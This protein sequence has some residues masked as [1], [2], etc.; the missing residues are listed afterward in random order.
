MKATIHAAVFVVAL[1][2]IAVVSCSDSTGPGK[3]CSTGKPCGRTCIAK[4][5]TCRI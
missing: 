3:N 4:T 5:D 2:V 1:V